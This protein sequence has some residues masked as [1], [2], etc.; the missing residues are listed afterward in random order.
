MKRGTVIFCCVSLVLFTCCLAYLVDHGV[1]N[2]FDSAVVVCVVTTGLPPALLAWHA[3]LR[4]NTLL[5][6]G[7]YEIVR[8]GANGQDYEPVDADAQEDQEGGQASSHLAAMNR[9]TPAILAL[10]LALTA[11]TELVRDAASTNE[12]K[13]H[14]IV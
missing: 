7:H 10:T 4:L 1:R 12:G 8:G 13:A 2:G 14:H 11:N 3:F 5:S 6:A 9:L